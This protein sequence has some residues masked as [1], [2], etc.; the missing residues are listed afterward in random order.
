MKRIVTV[1]ALTVVTWTLPAH[2]AGPQP[3]LSMQSL[4]AGNGRVATDARHPTL[5][6]WWVLQ[7]VAERAGIGVGAS[8]PVAQ[9]SYPVPA[10]IW[11]INHLRAATGG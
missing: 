10:P 4:A 2:A 9:T 11:I 8:A 6:A 3:A 5:C 1:A 7:N